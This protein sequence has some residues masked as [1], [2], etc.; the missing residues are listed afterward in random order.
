MT[1]LGNPFQKLFNLHAM[2][3]TRIAWKEKGET[4]VFTNGV[5]DILHPGHVLYLKEAA[6]LGTKLIVGLNA[7]ASVRMLNKG[8][9]RPIQDEQARATLLSALSMVDGVVM[10][11]EATPLNLITMLRPDV[12]VKGGDYTLE[13][14]VGSKEVIAYGGEV[15]QLQFVDGYSTTSI[16]QKIRSNG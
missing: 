4:V 13:Q 9:S 16:E 14:I 5:F 3:E 2:V 15:K 10:F 11:S 7:D 1:T 8:E 6:A 12:L